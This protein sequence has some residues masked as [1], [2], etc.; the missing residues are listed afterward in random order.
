VLLGTVGAPQTQATSDRSTASIRCAPPIVTTGNVD[1]IAAVLADPRRAWRLE[2]AARKV[3]AANSTRLIYSTDTMPGSSGSPVFNDEWVLVAVPA[4]V[5]TR[6]AAWLNAYD[7]LDI[8]ALVHPLAG[9]FRESVAGQLADERT[10]NPTGPH[11]IEDYL[12]DP[13][14]AV[15]IARA[16]KE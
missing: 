5:P 8:V 3:A 2:P 7:V 15:P 11:A 4:N 16:M 13:D 6:P 12:A 14:V 1:K 9:T 10:H